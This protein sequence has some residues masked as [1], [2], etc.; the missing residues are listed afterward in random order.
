MVCEEKRPKE[1]L[2]NFLGHS[3]LWQEVVKMESS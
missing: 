2:G 3:I 1:M